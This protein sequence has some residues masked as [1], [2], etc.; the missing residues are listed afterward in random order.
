MYEENYIVLQINLWIGAKIVTSGEAC[1][2]REVANVNNLSIIL[3]TDLC[4]LHV[5]NSSK[6]LAIFR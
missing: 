6:N 3:E 2:V 5:V 1:L 4:R